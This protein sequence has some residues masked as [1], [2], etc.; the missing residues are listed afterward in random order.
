MTLTETVNYFI[1]ELEGDL[2][3]IAWQIQEETNFEDN[4]LDFL[5]EQYEYRVEHLNN[6]KEIKSILEQQQ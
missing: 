6:L 3:D 4:N 2:E 1:E 5:S